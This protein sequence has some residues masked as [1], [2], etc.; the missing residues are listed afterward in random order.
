MIKVKCYPD[1]RRK[2]GCPFQKSS[3]GPIASKAPKKPYRLGKDITFPPPYPS[4]L[5]LF[6]SFLPCRAIA[7]HS[8]GGERRRRAGRERK[9]NKWKRRRRA[10][11]FPPHRLIYLAEKD[12][13]QLSIL[14]CAV[15]AYFRATR[16][17]GR[18]MEEFKPTNLDVSLF[19]G[20]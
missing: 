11:F 10:F 6:G 8:S 1:N 5:P 12:L 14:E 13:E 2:V 16:G 15:W 19:P 18:C 17:V 4:S 7:F 20:G 9:K 3:I